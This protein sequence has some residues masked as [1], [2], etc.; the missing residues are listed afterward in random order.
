MPDVDPGDYSI[1]SR[2][3]RMGEGG[4]TITTDVATAPA[5]V[6]VIGGENPPLCIQV[7]QTPGAAVE[8]RLEFSSGRTS[9]ESP[10]ALTFLRIDRLDRREVVVVRIEPGATLFRLDEMGPGDYSV[11][12]ERAALPPGRPGA[13][14]HVG[15]VPSHLTVPG[16]APVSVVL[17]IADE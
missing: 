11:S 1:R 9:D 8:G 7:E 15:V 13:A 12:V 10:I 3:T 2:W 6:T 14:R 4:E 16:L 5:A 17:E